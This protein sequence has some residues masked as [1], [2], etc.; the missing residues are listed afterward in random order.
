[1]GIYISKVTATPIIINV[2]NIFGLNISCSQISNASIQFFEVYILRFGWVRQLNRQGW[3]VGWGVQKFSN[4][5]INLYLRPQLR[6][7]FPIENRA[8]E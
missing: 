4:A 8:R 3:Q 2:K 6:L 5:I 7:P 1:M